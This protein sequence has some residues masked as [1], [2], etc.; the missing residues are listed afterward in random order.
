MAREF[1]TEIVVLERNK[2]QAYYCGSI[3]ITRYKLY[4][5]RV[6]LTQN[7]DIQH[8]YAHEARQTVA[9]S[10]TAHHH[11][12]IHICV[13]TK[14]FAMCSCSCC[15]PLHRALNI[16]MSLPC[17]PC[18]ILS[19]A[20]S[21]GSA[22]TRITGISHF[23]WTNMFLAITTIA[24]DQLFFCESMRACTS[25]SYDETVYVA[26]IKLWNGP[27]Y[28]CCIRC[29]NSALGKST[30]II[31]TKLHDAKTLLRYYILINKHTRN[32]YH[33]KVL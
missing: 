14:A 10:T 8:Y 24:L 28:W 15:L 7:T 29:L 4:I 26:S 32:R 22:V 11:T 5:C 3:N 2:A 9:L 19:R 20:C 23:I 17:V 30:F 16:C 12:H 25:L 21:T 27:R 33:K 13:C 18:C 1:L 6:Q 31:F